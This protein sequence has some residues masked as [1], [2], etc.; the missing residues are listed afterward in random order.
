MTALSDKKFETVRNLVESVPDSV[1]DSL[2]K[3][4]TLHV[5]DVALAPVRELVEAEARDR[6]LR[7]AVL[8]PVAALC[9]TDGRNRRRLTFPAQAMVHVWKGLAAWAPK[10]V[11]EA[12]EADATRGRFEPPPPIFDIL[13]LRAAEGMRQLQHPEFKAAAALLDAARPDGAAQ[14]IACLELSPV[15]RQAMFRA[16]TWIARPGEDSTAAVRLA[17]KDAVAMSADAGPRFFE[18][19]SAAL[20]PRCLVLRLISA[21]MD[22][23]SERFMA[24]SEFAMFGEGLIA[25]I[26]GM[27]GIVTGL[28]AEDGVEA[29]QRAGVKAVKIT[30]L[31]HEI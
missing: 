8:Y 22:R 24:E 17:Y 30:G 15:A 9:T 7:T 1:V 29:G 12:A 14:F 27:M 23:P 26:D 6:R 28:R 19:L 11:A 21:V 10:L 16:P 2:Q 25:D 4:L 13:T 3:A 5:T 20:K 18:M 31:V